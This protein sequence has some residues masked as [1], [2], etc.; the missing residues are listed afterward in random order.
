MYLLP[1]V[2]WEGYR[3]KMPYAQLFH[4]DVSKTVFLFSSR[5]FA[6]VCGQPDGRLLEAVAS[7]LEL[8]QMASVEETIHDGRGSGVVAQ[9]FPPILQW[10]V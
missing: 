1:V 5:A 10:S 9:Q 4:I 7:A 6:F 3:D 8:E 2:T